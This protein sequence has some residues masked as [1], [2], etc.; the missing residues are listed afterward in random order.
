MKYLT[1]IFLFITI[2]LYAQQDDMFL[3]D[4]LL[5]DELK[6]ENFLEKY[7]TTD[8]SEL[9]TQTANHRIK[10]MIGANHQRIRIALLSISQNSNVPFEYSVIGK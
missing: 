10:G 4:F 3:S 9:W 8:I 6:K 5:E 1:I 2:G 7:Q